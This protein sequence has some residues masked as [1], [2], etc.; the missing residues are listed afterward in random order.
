MVTPC[1]C[2]QEAYAAIACE[3]LPLALA[4]ADGAAEFAEEDEAEVDDEEQP[5]S[6]RPVASRA[7]APTVRMVVRDKAGAS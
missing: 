1:C 4:L 6:S 2:R 5:V 7:A 3:R